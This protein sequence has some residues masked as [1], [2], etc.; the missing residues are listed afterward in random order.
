MIAPQSYKDVIEWNEIARPTPPTLE[1][2]GD[3]VCEEINELKDAKYIGD[4]LD[5]YA[6]IFF[7]A[8]YL[9]H[10]LEGK[11][12]DL[13]THAEE[14]L[15]KA[16][17]DVGHIILVDCIHE[18]VRSNYTK[19]VDIGHGVYKSNNKAVE[20]LVSSEI[21]RLEKQTGHSIYSRRVGDYIVFLN[22]NN[23]VMKPYCYTPPNFDSVLNLLKE[24]GIE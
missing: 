11:S 24:R 23:K 10:L 5:A 17:R 1:E 21:E 4:V 9:L 12:N 16:V 13:M 3:I 15:T 22:E 14:E 2:Q 7:T 18:V 20:A 6:D 19:F 8:A